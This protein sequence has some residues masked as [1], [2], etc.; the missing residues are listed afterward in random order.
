MATTVEFTTDDAGHVAFIDDESI[1]I[2]R[3]V[4][5]KDD[6]NVKFQRKVK[7]SREMFAQLAAGAHAA[8]WF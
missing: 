7:M 6:G 2:E 3:V 1:S 5:Y 8:G 4:G